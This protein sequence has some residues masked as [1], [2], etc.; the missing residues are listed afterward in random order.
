MKM[1][2]YTSEACLRVCVTKGSLH[3][4]TAV[5]SEIL[6]AVVMK[7]SA[8]LSAEIQMTF[9]RNNS[10]PLSGSKSRSSRKPFEADSKQSNQPNERSSFYK[11][12]QEGA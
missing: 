4:Y 6:T 10:P 2:M 7:I 9:Q 11:G 1:N 5:G 3:D 12:T 8:V